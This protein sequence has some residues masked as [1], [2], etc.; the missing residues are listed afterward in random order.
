VNL[1]FV[2]DHRIGSRK[3]FTADHACEMLGFLVLME[4]NFVS[5]NFIAVVA[6]GLKIAQ[7]SFFSSHLDFNI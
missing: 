5:K 6:E 7:I 1:G 2:A 3:L 4:N